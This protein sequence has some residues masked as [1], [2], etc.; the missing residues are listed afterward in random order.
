M[1]F[2]ISLFTLLTLSS[3]FVFAAKSKVVADFYKESETL[4]NSPKNSAAKIKELEQSFK[5]TLDQY[6][7][8]NPKAGDKT[9]QEVSLLFYTL[10]P[11]FK[12]AKTK[13]IETLDCERTRQ[14]IKTGDGMGRPEDSVASKQANEAYKWLELL[15]PETIE[16]IPS[17]Q[18]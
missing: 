2:A 9:E 10:E 17:S 18:K 5:T 7:K 15:C 14:E 12:L 6:E 3:S 11:V 1:R 8:E 16:E 13:K 4:R